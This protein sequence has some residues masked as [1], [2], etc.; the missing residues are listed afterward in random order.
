MMAWQSAGR[1]RTRKKYHRPQCPL[2]LQVL[3]YSHIQHKNHNPGI[4][5]TLEVLV[6]LVA[7][8]TMVAVVALVALVPLIAFVV[9]VALC[10]A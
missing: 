6:A 10:W 2:T 7:L 1:W 3:I 9:M 8:V 4:L 5:V